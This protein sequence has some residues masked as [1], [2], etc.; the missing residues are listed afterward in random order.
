MYPYKQYQIKDF[1]K[2][3]KIIQEYPLAI[4]ISIN[5]DDC[6]ISHVP[7][8]LQEDKKSSKLIG[9][10]DKNNPQ[11]NFLNQKK[12]QILFQAVDSYI[13]PN[14]Y[15]SSQLPT[16]NFITIEIKGF[17]NEIDNRDEK[18]KLLIQT[19]KRFEKGN[20]P[21][22]LKYDDSRMDKLID[23]ITT[24]EIGI[25][26]WKGIIKMSQEKLQEDFE[27]AKQKLIQNSQRSIKNFIDDLTN[28]FYKS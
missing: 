26:N 27:K 1:G 16:W 13:S 18:K 2:I 12:I 28:D 20:N 14:D 3:I 21:F 15:V 24:F 10:I 17:V 9:H 6:L 25:K 5:N 23:Y 8:Y 4:L 19:T 22:I 7:L 11:S